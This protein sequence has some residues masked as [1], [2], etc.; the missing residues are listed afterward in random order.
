MIVAMI[1]SARSWGPLGDRGARRNAVASWVI[2]GLVERPRRPTPGP[3][4]SPS[5]VPLLRRLCR[6]ALRTRPAPER[7]QLTISG[8]PPLG[9]R[10]AETALGR[11]PSLLRPRPSSVIEIGKVDK[12]IFQ[13]SLYHLALGTGRSSVGG[14]LGACSVDVGVD[15]SRGHVHGPCCHVLGA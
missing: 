14:I 1:Y 4:Q 7:T 13:C 15:G 8:C 3:H 11:R 10:S 12:A 6:R 5:R 2:V 9:H